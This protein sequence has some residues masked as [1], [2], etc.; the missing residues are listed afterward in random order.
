MVSECPNH[1]DPRN[2]QKSPR[3]FSHVKS[4]FRRWGIP[5]KTQTPLPVSNGCNFW[6]KDVQMYH[7]NVSF[8]PLELGRSRVPAGHVSAGAA[9]A[10]P[11]V[12]T[13]YEEAESSKPHPA[14]TTCKPSTLRS[15]PGARHSGTC[16]GACPAARSRQH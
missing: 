12:C 13:P 5:Q 7:A 10:G 1:V 15:Q 9:S 8:T 14:P 6:T 3:I 4:F 2:V 11:S 16:P